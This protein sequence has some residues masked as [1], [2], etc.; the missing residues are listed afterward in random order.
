M[1]FRIGI[2]VGGTFTDLAA[3]NESTGE[4]FVSKSP[5]TPS[6]FVQGILNCLNKS[7]LR[8][9]RISYIVHGTT[10][11]TNA[12]VQRRFESTALIATKG[13]RD[14]LE[15]MRQN[16]PMWGLFD[17]QWDKPKPLIPRHLRFEVD[18]RIDAKGTI[19]K[20]LDENEVRSLVAKFRQL[21]IKSVAVCFMF[22]QLNP[23]HEERTRE[24]FR[25]EAPEIHLSLSSEVNPQIREYERSST[26]A[27]DAV[28]KPLAKKY[29]SHL[30]QGLRQSG[31]SST[32]LI[33][34]SNGGLISVKQAGDFPVY[35]LESGPAGGTIGAAFLGDAIGQRN[36]IAIDMGGTTF[37][38]S[39]VDTG[40]ARTR[41]EG[42][43]EWGIP[44]RVPMIDISEIGAGGGSIA[45]IDREGILR[46]GPQSAGADPGPV[47]YGMGGKE[48]TFT[49]AC[50]ALGY[51]NPEYLLGGE[52]RVDKKNAEDVIHRKIADP[53]HL[54]PIEAAYGIVE[55]SNQIMLGSMR[56]SSVEKGY[57]PREFATMAYGGAGP[58]IA[59]YLTKE[60]GSRLLIIP[61][62]PGI[63]SAIGMLVSDIRLDFMRPFH[64]RVRGADLDQVNK[65]YRMMEAEAV[66]SLKKDF[67]R[68]SYRIMR[69]ADMRYVGQNY[70]LNA[71]VPSGHESERTMR[72]AEHNFAK[73]HQKMYGHAK[74]VEVEFVNL[75]VTVFGVIRKPRLRSLPA[76]KNSAK[77][78]A[79][80]EV[81]FG[82]RA[83]FVNT[84]VY[85]RSIL[86][87]GT[88]LEGPS[89]LEE[90]DSTIVVYPKQ[91]ASVDEYGNIL[92]RTR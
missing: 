19:V 79:K 47:C 31:F 85:D 50:L 17:I 23:K 38:V 28:S 62:H 10:V 65:V 18:E 34:K 26:T 75:R 5:T 33:M 41:S 40:I 59:G 89:I 53:L 6:D 76:A 3:L 70:E 55:V 37:K 11:V 57:D 78:K 7:R 83:S 22:S 82:R 52:M 9:K 1:P 66:K 46:V 87:A 74:G 58:V 4:I 35:T 14:V 72:T 42:E 80:R 8:D 25:K 71:A 13:F 29:F 90:T 32:L 64:H 73:E 68:M 16:R 69:T 27:I 88:E 56:V 45:W 61:P 36:L 91:K 51:L 20:P 67:P 30:K 2:D 86:G 24:I 21:G 63:F 92:I 60:L 84:P 44:Y 12:I 81:Y 77:Q 48:P 39:V 43:V 15:I 54:D 49:D